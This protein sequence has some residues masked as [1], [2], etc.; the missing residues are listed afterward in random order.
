MPG[1]QSGTGNKNMLKFKQV[2][3]ALA[4]V[5]LASPA[6]GASFVN[7]GFED[8]TTNG[9]TIG[10]GSRVNVYNSTYPPL[11]NPADYLPGGTL[12]NSTIAGS[13]SSIISA[14]TIDPRVGAALGSTV[15]SGNYS[16][17]VEDTS[18]GG[19]ASVLTQTVTDYT[20]S[21]IF[22]AW[23]AVL[24]GAHNDYDAATMLLTL[25][26]LT[27]GNELIRRQYNAASSG[28]GVDPRFSSLNRVFYTPQWQIE[29]LTIDAALS[30]HNFA[31]S[32]LAA[33]CEQTGH[34]G[35]VYLDGFGRVAPN[36]TVPVPGGLA[37]LGIGA[38]GLGIVRRKS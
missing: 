2:A 19:Y 21:D 28:G 20:D 1:S 8:G 26:D 22:F 12:Y 16:M 35:Y 36:P 17:R 27:T 13:H 34:Y 9:W 7:G 29:Q 10:G 31:L 25:T 30:G 15:H 37:L 6:W 5:G 38:I 11:L 32:V 14:G 4:V 24:Q 33:D 3:A 23:K 18:T